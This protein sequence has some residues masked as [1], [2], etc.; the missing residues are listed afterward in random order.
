MK[1]CTQCQERKPLSEFYADKKMRDGRK[2]WCKKCHIAKVQAYRAKN[3]D[4]V[5]AWNQGHYEANREE[6]KAKALE[7]HRANRDREV[8]RMR[9]AYEENRE[10]RIA[11]QVE[12]NREHPDVYRDVQAKR[13]ARKRALPAEDV[14]RS[15]VFERDEGTCGICGEAVDPADWHLDHVVP[16]AKGGHHT[17]ENVQVAHPGCNQSKGAR[18]ERKAAMA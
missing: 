15:L 7:Y 3:P 2:S 4:K 1:T 17:Y 11:K 5:L 6:R 10:E 16:L 18:T 12:W 9:K 14:K 8:A 13:R